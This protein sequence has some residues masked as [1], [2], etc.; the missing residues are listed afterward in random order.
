MIKING[1][2]EKELGILFED[3]LPLEARAS[4]AYESIAIDGRNG[5][6]Y[7]SLGLRNVPISLNVQIL[8][9]EKIDVL[10]STL[11]GKVKIEYQD[12]ITYGFIFDSIDI[13]RWIFLRKTQINIL[14][15]PI[16]HKDEDFVTNY[17]NEGNYPSKPLI[18]IAKDKAQTVNV[19]INTLEFTYKFESNDQF[20]IIDCENKAAYTPE[21]VNRNRNLTIGWEF[22]T[23]NPGSN[24]ATISPNGALRFKNKDAW[25]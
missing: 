11:I 10:K 16:W 15:D 3:L 5:N 7:D 23:L 13:E 6:I 14:R 18:R 25:I 20:V 24:V 17:S 19:K 2:T 8:D 21:G 12:R 9:L 4:T 1:K 22:P